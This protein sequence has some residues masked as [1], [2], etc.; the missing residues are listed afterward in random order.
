MT[1]G[2]TSGLT[3]TVIAVMVLIILDV[4]VY[5]DAR[6]HTRQNEPVAVQ[7]G[8]FTIDAPRVWVAFCVVLFV[9]FFPLYLVARRASQ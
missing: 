6:S 3:V 8:G 1:A 4:W 2:V 9:I 7:L 5:L